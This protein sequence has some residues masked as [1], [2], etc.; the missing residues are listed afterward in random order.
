MNSGALAY[1][2]VVVTGKGRYAKTGGAAVRDLV[3]SGT[4]IFILFRYTAEQISHYL[5]L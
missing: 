1:G 3:R 4:R 2:G 5:R